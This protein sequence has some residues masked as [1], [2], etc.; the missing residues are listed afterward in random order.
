MDIGVFMPTTSTLFAIMAVGKPEALRAA[1]SKNIADMALEVVPGQWLVVRPST[2]TTVELAKELGIF[3]GSTSGAIVLNVASY[4][5][6][7][8]PSTWEWIAAKTGA[9]SDA[10][11][12]G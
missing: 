2:T 8:A 5:G 10:A 12:A 7:T 4:H 11:Q 9:T 1:I 3:D 6:R